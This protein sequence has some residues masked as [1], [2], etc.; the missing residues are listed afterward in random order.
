MI[1]FGSVRLL[2]MFDISFLSDNRVTKLLP[3]V[4]FPSAPWATDETIKGKVFHRHTKSSSWFTIMEV[5]YPWKQLCHSVQHTQCHFSW[6]VST[7]APCWCWAE[8][9][10]FKIVL[11][12]LRRG[13]LV[14][15]LCHFGFKHSFQG[16]CINIQQY[17]GAGKA[18]CFLWFFL[19][20]PP[21]LHKCVGKIRIIRHNQ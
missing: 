3:L 8:Q 18:C 4:Q 21:V 11:L 13:G 9:V 6:H 19:Q 16:F 2:L 5:N 12:H 15:F 10:W 7:A 20:V 17:R 1:F 14:S